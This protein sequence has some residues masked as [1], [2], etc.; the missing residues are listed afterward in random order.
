MSKLSR[1]V[2]LALEYIESNLRSPIRL[3]GIS[4]YVKM[5]DSY[6]SGIFMSETGESPTRCALR[7]KLEESKRLLTDTDKSISQI[8]SMFSFCSPSHYSDTFKKEYG[9]TPRQCR[10]RHLREKERH[11]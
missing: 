5:S 1:P 8:S 10:R 4:E 7:R 11:S 9:E 6:L 3:S 2:M